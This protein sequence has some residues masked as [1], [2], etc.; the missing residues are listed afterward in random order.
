VALVA[1]AIAVMIIIIS[2]ITMATSSGDS[3]SFKNARN[4]V[5]YAS[6]GLAIIMIAE[7]LVALV[8]N[9]VG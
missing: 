7:A 6:V 8:L 9:G 4:G 5:I 2:G 3:Q 1:G